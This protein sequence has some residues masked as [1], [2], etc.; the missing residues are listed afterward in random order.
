MQYL[1]TA[2]R[3][4]FSHPPASAMNPPIVKANPV[5]QLKHRLGVQT[6]LQ[7]AGTARAKREHHVVVLGL[8]CAAAFAAAGGKTE[9]RRLPKGRNDNPKRV[10]IRIES[11]VA[12]LRRRRRHET[13]CC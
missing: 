3:H 8:R 13:C 1:K 9:G 10:A 4:K 2:R 5:A 11:V 6:Q 12:N 7:G